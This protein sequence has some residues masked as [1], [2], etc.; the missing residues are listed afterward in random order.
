M[1][2][3][4]YENYLLKNGHNSTGAERYVK[5][6]ER[7]EREASKDMDT[8][9]CS[10]AEIDRTKDV[11]KTSPSYRDLRAALHAYRDFAESTTSGWVISTPASSTTGSWKTYKDVAGL[12]NYENSVRSY[13]KVTGLCDYIEI[14]YD[15]IREFARKTLIPIWR[16]FPAIPVYLSKECPK[17]VYP[18]D[19]RAIEKRIREICDKCDRRNCNPPRCR[20]FNEI[21]E[22]ECIVDK[23][24]GRFYGGEEP[25][26]VIY[27]R[28]CDIEPNM[29][30]SEYL[31]VVAE[32]L[33]HEY[34]HFIHAYYVFEAT[35]NAVEPFKKKE[36]SEALAD[37]FG[38][39]YS[40]KN[41]GKSVASQRYDLW[42]WRKGTNWPYWNALRFF[43][44]PY[45]K[46]LIDYTGAEIDCAVKK[47]RDVF[48]NTTNPTKA[49][50]ILKK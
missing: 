35:K 33:A 8:I 1:R 25:H 27:F 40:L 38:V 5:L 23:I 4:G 34:M 14:E 50:E 11:L 12:V 22:N 10:P 32:T 44:K 47:F 2:K 37:F 48:K 46:S 31:S 30:D 28:N 39:L 3:N 18:L 24:F 9:V 16:D 15:K 20:A 17:E 26:I 21:W 29:S 43:S 19:R 45:K 41:G 7:I 36:L 49:M 42:K 13:E 6:C